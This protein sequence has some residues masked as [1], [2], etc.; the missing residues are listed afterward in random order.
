MSSSVCE[1]ILFSSIASLSPLL[2]FTSGTLELPHSSDPINIEVIT[3]PEPTNEIKPSSSNT[4]IVNNNQPTSSSLKTRHAPTP[5]PNLLQITIDNTTYTVPTK[6]KYN[7]LGDPVF[8]ESGIL[9]P[10]S[11]PQK[12][13][14]NPIQ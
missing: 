5:P 13:L 11:N 12:I 4:S 1:E 3:T 7:I 8:N 6:K 14:L 10:T 2:S 9:P